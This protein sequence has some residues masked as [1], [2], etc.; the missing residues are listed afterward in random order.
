MTGLYFASYAYD[1]TFLLTEDKLI[2]RFPSVDMEDEVLVF[3]REGDNI[4][5]DKEASKNED[6]FKYKDGDMFVLKGEDNEDEITEDLEDAVIEYDKNDTGCAEYVALRVPSI[7]ACIECGGCTATCTAGN[8]TE[9]NIRKIQMLM[10]RG[11]NKICFE[12]LHKCM[13]CHGN[14]AFLLH[15][16]SVKQ[17]KNQVVGHGKF[18]RHAEAAVFIV[19]AFQEIVRGTFYDISLFF[20]CPGFLSGQKPHRLFCGGHDPVTV[21]F[22][23]CLHRF[24]KLKEAWHPVL[25]LF[26][27]IRSCKKRLFIRR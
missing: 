21:H 11:E 7:S 1:G 22:P 16:F 8:F 19:I 27:K 12:H 3:R 15:L 17:Q 26:G 25:L 4:I 2:L 20:F 6:L 13:L 14:D 24:Q 9:F 5:Y 10:R 18:G 23:L